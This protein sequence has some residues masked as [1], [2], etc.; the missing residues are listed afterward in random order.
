MFYDPFLYSLLRARLWA[1][2]T[3]SLPQATVASRA[4][5]EASSSLITNPIQSK[6]KTHTLP[7]PSHPHLSLIN[8]QPTTHW[9]HP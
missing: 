8:D 1:L 9:P 4:L 2:K 3:E 7:K 6:I 5:Q